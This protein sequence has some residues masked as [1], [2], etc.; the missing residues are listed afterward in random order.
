MTEKGKNCGNYI[1]IFLIFQ[2]TFDLDI[3]D[4]I[5]VSIA[6]KSCQII[7]ACEGKIA[8]S[9]IEKNMRLVETEKIVVGKVD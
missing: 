5:T 9:E 8:S 3:V 7:H 2:T 6:V 4:T 1:H